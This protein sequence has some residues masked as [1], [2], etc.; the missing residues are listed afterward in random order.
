MLST[1]HFGSSLHST[2]SMSRKGHSGPITRQ[3]AVALRGA[4]GA[5]KS[6]T[7]GSI[8][9]ICLCPVAKWVHAA[10]VLVMLCDL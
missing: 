2:I 8:V 7:E 1:S 9:S 4:T 10:T 3:V 5:G 6:V